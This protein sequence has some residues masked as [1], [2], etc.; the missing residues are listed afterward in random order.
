MAGLHTLQLC[1][2]KCFGGL[3]LEEGLKGKDGDCLGWVLSKSCCYLLVSPTL[4]LSL[5][6]HWVNYVLNK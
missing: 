5:Y 3:A 4:A 1:M 2:K 6:K